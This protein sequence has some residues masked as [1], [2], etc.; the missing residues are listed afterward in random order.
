M[1]VTTGLDRWP[2][3]GFGFKVWNAHG[4]IIAE[5]TFWKLTAWLE[6]RL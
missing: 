3:W 1:K 6:I 5:V 4:F 2:L